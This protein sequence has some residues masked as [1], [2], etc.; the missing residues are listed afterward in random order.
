MNVVRVYPYGIARTRLERAIRERK[1]AAVIVGDVAQADAIITMRTNGASKPSKLRE[2]N[3]PIP[4]IT[5]KSNTFSQ[6]AQAL[7]DILKGPSESAEDEA[8]A[9]QE[10]AAALDQVHHTGRAVELAPQRA[11]LRKLQGQLAESRRVAVEAVGEEPN[12]RLRLLP[13]RL[14]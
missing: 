4:T 9:M 10:V 2:L 14:N 5:V 11:G 1:A 7:D 3:R 13:I 6:I 8:A 12:R